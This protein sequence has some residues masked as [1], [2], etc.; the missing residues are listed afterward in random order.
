MMRSYELRHD[1]EHSQRVDL[2]FNSSG[3]WFERNS[4]P[5]P[6]QSADRLCKGSLFECFQE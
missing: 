2:D 5:R 3:W 4:N 1:L 6:Q